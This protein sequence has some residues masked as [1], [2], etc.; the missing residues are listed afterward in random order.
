MVHS[1]G[2]RVQGSWF[3]VQGSGF[4]VYGLGLVFKAHRLL[5]QS[6]LGL[7]VIKKKKVYGLGLGFDR[8]PLSARTASPNILPASA[9]GLYRRS[10]EREFCIDNLQV[11]I[12]FIIEMIWWTGLA[13]WEF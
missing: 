7:R 5:Y 11:R 6:T 2:F 10:T 8:P 3:R 1:S 4:W 12:H 13:Q 9:G